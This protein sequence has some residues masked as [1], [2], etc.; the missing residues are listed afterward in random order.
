[1]IL[2][3]GSHGTLRHDRA[4][5]SRSARSSAPW[6]ECLGILHESITTKKMVAVSDMQFQ[7]ELSFRTFRASKAYK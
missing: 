3:T 5:R 2:P 4:A 6:D 7:E 1:V